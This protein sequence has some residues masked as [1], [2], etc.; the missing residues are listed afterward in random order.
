[1]FGAASV[2]A[3]DLDPDMVTRADERTRRRAHEA[4]VMHAPPASTTPSQTSQVRR[5]SRSANRSTRQL[6]AP[7]SSRHAAALSRL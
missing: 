5:S 1:V 4:E 3:F 7:T 6:S 2:D